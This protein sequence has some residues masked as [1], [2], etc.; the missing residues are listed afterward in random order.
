MSK[1]VATMHTKQSPMHQSN[2]DISS[3]YHNSSFAK[4]QVTQSH[5]NS[6]A[7]LPSS[8]DHAPRIKN[9]FQIDQGTRSIMINQESDPKLN[10]LPYER[11]QMGNQS[12][13]SMNPDTSISAF[14]TV[15]QNPN[16][17]SQMRRIP[18]LI[19]SRANINTDGD[20]HGYI[21]N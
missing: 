6:M 8:L 16:N 1:K 9:K 2:V 21:T 15:D 3:T 10:L 11:A 4:E 14:D 12:A 7:N 13:A 18:M 19:Q 20:V 17:H 5:L